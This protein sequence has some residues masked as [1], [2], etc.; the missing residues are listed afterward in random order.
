MAKRL[1]VIV[2]I[3]AVAIFSSLP[4]FSGGYWTRVAT[5]VSM[6]I[7]LSSSW[8]LIGGFAGYASFGH[9]A[10]FG[11]GAYTAGVLMKVYNFPFPAAVVGSLLLAAVLAVV[12]SPVMRLKGHYFAIAT[13]AVAEAAREFIANMTITGGGS[14]MSFPVRAGGIEANNYFYFY[15][16]LAGA[17]LMVLVCFLI[18]RSRVGFA[19]LA[20]KASEDTAQSLGINVE[21]YKMVAL[22]ISSAGVA[23]AGA[24]YGYWLT[25]ID[26]GSTFN[27]HVSVTM[28]IMALLGGAGTVFGPAVGAVL[29]EV[30]T[31]LTWS[32]FLELSNLVLGI[33]MV[34]LILFLPRGLV[35]L[36][37]GETRKSGKRKTTGR[38]SI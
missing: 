24:I 9:A 13:L 12:I 36:L 4:L 38:Y 29:F 33:V 8:N 28:I 10:F 20:V 19:M 22:L 3:L 14:G 25:F 26:P 7:I 17:A 37:N 35:S 15:L 6:S 18:R 5:F 16:M 32:H 31:E 1:S 27:V 2:G 23:M 21:R 11:L 30:L 34:L